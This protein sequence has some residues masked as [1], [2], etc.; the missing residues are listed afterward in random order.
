MTQPKPSTSDASSKKPGSSFN[1]GGL[2]G[3]ANR[4]EIRKEARRVNVP[5]Q[6]RR[7]AE[8]SK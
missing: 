1:K 4:Q 2:R 3:K 5:R 7:P 8:R 6:S